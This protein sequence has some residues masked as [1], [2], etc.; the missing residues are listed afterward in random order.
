MRERR[1]L[2]AARRTCPFQERPVRF[3]HKTTVSLRFFTKPRLYTKTGPTY[4]AA[5]TTSC[6]GQ[7]IVKARH[8]TQDASGPTRQ[9]VSSNPVRRRTT[10]ALYLGRD[11]PRFLRGSCWARGLSSANDS[12]MREPQGDRRGCRRHAG[13]HRFNDGLRRRHRAIG[14][15]TSRAAI[16]FSQRSP[17]I[18]H[19]SS[20]S[21][22]R[23]E[24]PCCV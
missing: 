20:R 15:H 13:G 14:S 9:M 11:V 4:V 5:I 7:R 10:N 18:H 21:A 12:D 24:M 16:L 2:H 23:Q 6:T 1:N 8:I 19:G 3:K 22:R 17:C